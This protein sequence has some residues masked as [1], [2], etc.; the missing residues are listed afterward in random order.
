MHYKISFL[1]SAK[2]VRSFDIVDNGEL[3]LSPSN[4][5]F[6][7]EFTAQALHR[8]AKNLSSITEPAS[9]QTVARAIQHYFAPELRAVQQKLEAENGFSDHQEISIN[10]P[11]DVTA[12]SK[13]I[14]A[15]K[16]NNTLDYSGVERNFDMLTEWLNLTTTEQKFLRLAYCVS[17]DIGRGLISSDEEDYSVGTLLGTLSQ[18]NF[19]N[20]AEK[21]RVI[22]VILEEP[23]DAVQALFTP[24]CRLISLRFMSADYWHIATNV[25]LTLGVTE[26]FVALLETPYRSTAA[27]RES[28][29]QQEFDWKLQVEKKS[30]MQ[31][32][33]RE[34]NKQP[35]WFCY[36]QKILGLSYTAANI[37][38]I[39]HWFTGHEINTAVLE[40]LSYQLGFEAI[41]EAIKRAA[42]ECGEAAQPLTEI[43]ILRALYAATAIPKTSVE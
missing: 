12:F 9:F 25:F 36:S 27:M 32:L 37:K 18:I 20:Q 42:I 11:L 6:I 35:I 40:P 10:E 13:E 23:I 34:L 33:K 24:P 5:N 21:H 41:R 30:A 29:L 2:S 16:F 7:G 1:N 22:A 31:T 28:W 39:I 15:I 17:R 14:E 3:V 43:A 38:T 4:I 8:I 26:E 19:E